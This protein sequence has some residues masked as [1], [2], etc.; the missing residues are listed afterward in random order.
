MSEPEWLVKPLNELS[1]TQ[2][3]ALCDGCGKCCM[4]KLLDTGTDKIY[5][6][7]VA[8]E[9]FDDQTCRC[10]DYDNRT[11]RVPECMQ[12]SLKNIDVFSWLPSTCA[13]RLRF[14]SKPLYDWHPLINGQSDLMHMDNHSVQN[15]TVSPADAGPLEHHLVSWE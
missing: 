13:Y 7:N 11:T 15:K 2:W 14:E 6:T 8:C 3:E 12:I 1:Q 4:S 5:Y 10:K 9:L